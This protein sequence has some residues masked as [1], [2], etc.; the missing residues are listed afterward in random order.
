MI[1][2]TY[3]YKYDKNMKWVD[4]VSVFYQLH[5][6]IIIKSTMKLNLLKKKQLL[7][8]YNKKKIIMH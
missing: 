7:Y 5:L 3:L 4:S 1:I 2:Y 6:I 8:M